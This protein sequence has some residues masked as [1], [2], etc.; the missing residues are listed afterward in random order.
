MCHSSGKIVGRRGQPGV[1]GTQ[2][3]WLTWLAVLVTA[4]GIVVLLSKV[5][6]GDAPIRR[7]N[8]VMAEA[9]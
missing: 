1:A 7:S 9:I 4:I 2:R 6:L 3:R 8:A 5:V